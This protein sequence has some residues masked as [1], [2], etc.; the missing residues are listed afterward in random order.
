MISLERVQQRL[1]NPLSFVIYFTIVAL[2][3]INLDRL[4]AMRIHS[5]D[6][7]WFKY[8]LLGLTQFGNQAVY[9]V[10]L[11]VIALFYRYVSV[12]RSLE[13]RLWFLWLCFVIAQLL[14]LILKIFFGRARP[15]LFLDAQIFGFYG[16]QFKAAY[17]SFPS[18][19]TMAIMT[20]MWGLGTFYP[21]KWI[22]FILFGLIVACSRVLLSHHFLSDVLAAFYLSGLVVYCLNSRFNFWQYTQGHR[23]S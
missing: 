20:L 15:E 8:I 21:K 12:H 10:L 23:N 1:F 6:F 9:L 7:L 3:F 19:H 18:G 14:C 13:A 16:F 5:I 17:W 2:C 22:Y 4:L 11:P